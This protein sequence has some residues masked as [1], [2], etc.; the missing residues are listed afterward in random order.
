ML[1]KSPCLVYI[2]VYKEDKSGESRSRTLYRWTAKTF[3]SHSK[4][5]YSIK[6]SKKK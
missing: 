1:G 4:V 3:K 6:R 2:R 5:F